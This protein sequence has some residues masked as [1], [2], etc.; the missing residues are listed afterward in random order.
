MARRSIPKNRNWTGIFEGE[1]F[2]NLFLTKNIN[3]YRNKGKLVL[4]DALSSVFD[5]DNDADLTTHKIASLSR[6][7]IL[8]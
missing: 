6:C 3:L 4:G 7:I 5:S 8:I 2:G 1:Y